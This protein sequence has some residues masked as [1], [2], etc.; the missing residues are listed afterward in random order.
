MKF[1]L[2]FMLTGL[3]VLSCKKEPRTER[4]LTADSIIADTIVSEQPMP[5]PAAS[6]SMRIADSISQQKLKDTAKATKK[7]AMPK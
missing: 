3:M 2:L 7:K 1:T 5:P 6:D 4:P